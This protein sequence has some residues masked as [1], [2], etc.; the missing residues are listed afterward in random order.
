MW[1][2]RNR[3][4][5]PAFWNLDTSLF[6]TFPIRELLKIEFRA[7]AFNIFN[8]V[9][10]GQPNNDMA[11]TANFGK[12]LGTANSPRQLQLGARIIW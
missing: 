12:V 3:L 6:R 10:Y 5:T 8:A 4:R 2:G 1:V 7:E 11:D 9:I